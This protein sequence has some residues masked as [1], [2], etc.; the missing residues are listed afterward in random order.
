[1][2]FLGVFLHTGFLPAIAPPP[3]L[4]HTHEMLFGFAG[5]LIGGFLLTAV[6]N[7]TG[8]APVGRRRLWLL[9]AAWL[10]ARVGLCL[11]LPLALPAVLEL[12]YMLGLLAA[13]AW[14]VLR[15]PNR[16]NDFVIALLALY[17]GLDAVFFYGTAFNP[18]LAQRASLLTVDWLTVL[19][20]VIGGRVIPFFTGRRL[21]QCGARDV[22]PLA[23]AVNFGAGVT[24]ALDLFA[25][26]AGPRA[27]FWF[28]LAVL[29]LARWWCWRPP[30]TRREPMLWSLH[31]G[32]LWLAL[33]AALRGAVLAGGTALREPAA[34]HAITVGALGTLSVS[35]MTRVAQGHSGVAI[36]ANRPLILAFLLPSVAALLRIGGGASAWPAA[37][38]TF[39]AAYLIYLAAVGSLLVRSPASTASGASS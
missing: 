34:L 13:V 2:L 17:A 38:A 39:A 32:Y 18:A 25:A 29:I 33:G 6:A 7:W 23:R 12:G 4:W 37:A 21:P 11:P 35:M 22:K 27:A 9:F 14:V 19:M 15:T 1:M 24:F 31:L 8:R 36:A 26:P 16:R 10:G 30:A 28:A 3:I 5:S 20:L